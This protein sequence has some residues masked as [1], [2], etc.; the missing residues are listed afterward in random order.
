[1]SPPPASKRYVDERHGFSLA[2]TGA[3]FEYQAAPGKTGPDT[4]VVTVRSPSGEHEL[5]VLLA[6]PLPAKLQESTTFQVAGRVAA[7]VQDGRTSQP[8]P[9]ERPDRR[10]C[11]RVSYA[12]A[13]HQGAVV[14]VAGEERTYLLI[15]SFP[16]GES[17]RAVQDLLFIQLG[18][19]VLKRK[20]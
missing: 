3:S 13:T 15:S 18:L 7:M 16:L 12:S 19:V 6:P 10:A 20:R 11:F 1:M 5:I 4:P 9:L 2:R 17:S 8:V 14:S